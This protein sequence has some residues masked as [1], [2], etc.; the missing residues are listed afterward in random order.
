QY[1]GVTSIGN[2]IAK[3][4]NV[5]QIRFTKAGA[6]SGSVTSSPAGLDCSANCTVWFDQ[7]SAST[8]TATP[9]VG[10]VFTGWSGACSGTG[11]CALN[12]TEAKSV[13][14]T[15][16]KPPSKPSVKW[17]YSKAKRTVKAQVKRVPGVTYA[18]KATKGKAKKTGKCKLNQKTKKIDCT[19]RLSR[20]IWKAA[21][22]PKANG[23]SGPVATKRFRIR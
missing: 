4:L 23:L 20:G 2:G 21:V 12:L 11:P 9:A 22:T 13:T 10:S 18:L 5:R 14:A 1:D 3:V 7:A 17:S 15:F 19:V 16:A 8:L 6:G